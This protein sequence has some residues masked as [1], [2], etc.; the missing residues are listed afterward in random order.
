MNQEIERKI[1]IGLTVLIVI[2]L[3]FWNIK[4]MRADFVFTDLTIDP[5]Y[6][7]FGEGRYIGLL[8]VVIALF[9]INFLNKYSFV[10]TVTLG[11]LMTILYL[12]QTPPLVWEGA[13]TCLESIILMI[14]GAFRLKS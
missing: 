12:K 2:L 13:I 8:A 9:L 11:F 4:Q 10:I 5:Q 14:T 7:L 1:I 6:Y 3:P